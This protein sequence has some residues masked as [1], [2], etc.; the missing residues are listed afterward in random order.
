M[1]LSTSL[2]VR[3]GAPP[4]ADF[5]FLSI[6]PNGAVGE[7]KRYRLRDLQ[8]PPVVFPRD[9]ELSKGFAIRPTSEA[10]L[11]FVLTGAG[12]PI[13]QQLTAGLSNAIAD[14]RI[15]DGTRLWFPLLATGD[16]KLTEL[17]SLAALLNAIEEVSILRHCGARITI[18]VPDSLSGSELAALQA[19]AKN[20]S[21]YFSASSARGSSANVG[22][23]ERFA[24][25]AAQPYGADVQAL[26]SLAMTLSA[27]RTMPSSH[28]STT[29]LLFAIARADAPGAPKALAESAEARA[30]A[31]SLLHLA[32]PAFDLAWNEYFH[33]ENFEP[34]QPQPFKGMTDN[35]RRWLDSA[36]ELARKKG[37]TFISLA[38]LIGAFWTAKQGRA[39][40]VLAKMELPLSQLMAEYERRLLSSGDRTDRL[41]EIHDHL[42]HDHAT[43]LDLMDFH[44]Y[45]IAISNFL[46][47]PDTRGPISISI[48]APWGAGKSSLMQQVRHILDED[49]AAPREKGH[50][51]IRNVLNFLNRKRRRAGTDDA[52]QQGATA[53][54]ETRW[55]IWFNAWK[56]ESSE[57]VW[58]GM[59]DAI[60]S[61]VSDRL[62]PVER[63]LFLLR[64]NLARIDDG[65]VRMKIYD[66]M[67]R[68][69]WV[70]ARWLLLVGAAVLAGVWALQGGGPA[71][72]SVVTASALSLIGWLGRAW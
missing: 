11:V 38:E 26:L 63:E 29:L 55:T 68:Y 30:F 47:S 19:F 7:L 15:A 72:V 62:S 6:D 21:A 17:S 60:I 22:A 56:Y 48:Q 61:Q 44:Q 9:Q 71:M 18:S 31:A 16:G 53:P 24:G 69:W 4:D 27:R 64:L 41:L 35:S 33:P 58:A 45:A 42:V 14:L 5:V 1:L 37:S 39:L 50:A 43:N 34:D 67:A 10:T 23:D 3:R 49:A 70:G 8:L 54:S 66:R 57:Q 32:G 13:D 52:A 40:A 12:G 46:T 25:S 28:L 2:I 65:E 36:A 20:R 51:T 59:V